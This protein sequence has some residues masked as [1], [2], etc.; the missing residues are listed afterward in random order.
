MNKLM[1]GLLTLVLLFGCKDDEAPDPDLQIADYIA[2]E[3]LNV[4]T[5][6]SGLRYE[7]QEEGTGDLPV[8]NSILSITFTGKLTDGTIFTAGTTPVEVYITNQIE[9]L[10]EGFRL[11][12]NGSKATFI[13]P[14]DLG[15]GDLTAGEIPANSV[16]IYEIEVHGISNRI[17][18]EIDQYIEDNNLTV[19][20]TVEGLFYILNETGDDQRPNI[21][22]SIEINY[23]GRFV[24]GDVFDQSGDMPRTFPLSGLIRGW[25]IGIPLMGRGGDGLFIIPPQ[26][27][28][29][30]DGRTGIPG[31]AVLI[32]DIELLDF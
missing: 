4:T 28:Y 1:I 15:F 20:E 31:N 21:N 3:G 22:S 18:D 14:P 2:S 24:D 7:F 8:T 29:G 16:I 25:Q 23:E 19:T 10:A 6:A 27:G 12:R 26:L 17:Q 13:I 9:G 11:M 32:F 5:T 30:Q